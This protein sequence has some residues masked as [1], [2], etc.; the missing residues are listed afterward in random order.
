[1]REAPYVS[2][3]RVDVERRADGALLLTNPHPLRPAFDDVIAPLAGHAARRSDHLWLAG[4]EA[5]GSWRRLGYGEGWQQVQALA[6][7]LDAVLPAGVVVAIVSGN[8]IA[9][10]LMTY[11]LALCGR[12]PAPVT[13]AY[14]A[15]ARDSR[16]F[17]EAVTVLGASAVFV[18]G[19]ACARAADW[20]AA[21]GLTVIGKDVA[22]SGTTGTALLSLAALVAQG[23]ARLAAGWQPPPID[24]QAPAK[25]MLTSGSTG[26][27][28][29]VI[30]THA[31]LAANAAQ[32]RSTFDPGAEDRLWPDGIVMANHLP[33]SHSLGGNAV[34]HMLTVAGGSLWIDPGAPTPEGLAAT[35]E[36]LR[37]VRPNYHLTVPLGWSLL[38]GALEADVALAEALFANLRIMQYGGAALTQDVYTRLQ[39]VAQ[40]VTGEQITVAAGYGAT[41]TAPTVCNVH[42][43]NGRMGL[44]G[45]PV[46]GLTVKL[47]PT[48]DGKLEARVKGPGITPGYWR[49]AEKT[50]AAFDAEGYYCLGDALKFADPEKPEA[51]LVF[52]GRL[53]ETFKL[54]GGSWVPVGPVR[55][56]LVQASDGLFADAVIC[57]EGGEEVCA[58]AFLNLARART[59]TGRAQALLAELA[60]DPAIVAAAEEIVGRAG[61]GQPPTR[62]IVR[63]ALLP[64]GPSLED[65]EITDKGYLNQARCRAVR[66]QAVEAVCAVRA[67]VI[68]TPV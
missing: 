59:L 48:G 67:S 61:A 45:L 49:D 27:P 33:W 29:A 9:H 63:L 2:P 21:S 5:D 31:N 11:A 53:S 32:I 16:R 41:E 40:R 30:V 66:V 8:S 39:A 6:A 52:D 1:M 17:D 26:A 50:A 35:V 42:W 47:V 3:V 68:V 7:G 44:V 43:P 25:L 46:P 34:L 55:L 58:L 20:G 64:D 22:A 12:I 60:D 13:P 54:A 10:A 28:K 51:G 18:E 65:G 14:C 36:T 56:G 24:P 57:G 4:Q 38:A 23:Q 15:R 37:H 62:R 19:Q